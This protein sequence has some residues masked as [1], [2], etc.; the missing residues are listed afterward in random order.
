MAKYRKWCFRAYWRCEFVAILRI[1]AREQNDKRYQSEADIESPEM[2][3]KKEKQ[4]KTVL[5]TR[6]MPGHMLTHV[7]SCPTP[8]G[9]S[10][11]IIILQRQTVSLERRGSV[12]LNF[13]PRALLATKIDVKNHASGTHY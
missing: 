12:V 9:P 10:S 1:P 13:L 3:Q 6:C 5:V 11:R 7:Q 4:S 2:V 8:N